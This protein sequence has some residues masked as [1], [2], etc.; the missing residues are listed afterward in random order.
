MRK[1]AI[2]PMLITVSTSVSHAQDEAEWVSIDGPDEVRELLSGKFLEGEYW[3]DYYRE[4][5]AMAYINKVY[6]SVVVRKWVVDDDGKVCTY[7]YVKPDKLVDC[8]SRYW[9]S[10]QNPELIRIKRES[11]GHNSQAR[12]T[13]DPDRKLIDAINKTAGPLN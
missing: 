12:L 1:N 11:T 10:V 9:R 7:I 8:D 13:T 6:D 4:D 5:G 3:A 2:A